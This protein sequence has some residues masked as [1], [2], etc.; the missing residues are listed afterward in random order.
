MSNCTKCFE[1]I[2]KF[3]LG[4]NPSLPLSCGY[5]VKFYCRCP[6]GVCANGDENKS[7]KNPSGLEKIV[8]RSRESRGYVYSSV[9]LIYVVFRLCK[10]PKRMQ[11]CLSQGH[12]YTHKRETFQLQGALSHIGSRLAMCPG[13]ILSSRLP[14]LRAP[15]YIHVLCLSVTVKPENEI[16]V[17][18]FAR[19][20]LYSAVAS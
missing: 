1:R 14:N 5:W 20:R 8:S 7:C 17:N 15:Y 19:A 11:I 13:S 3:Y 2:S 12:K 10:I 16:N 6:C 4:K 9:N 18:T